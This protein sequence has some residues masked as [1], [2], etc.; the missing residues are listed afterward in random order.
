MTRLVG[1]RRKTFRLDG[2]YSVE[3]V[4]DQIASRFDAVWHPDVPPPL[5]FKKKRSIARYRQVRDTFFQELADEM[6]G[7]VVIMEM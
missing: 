2:T 4:F 6:G 1:Q 5:W 3:F 7:S